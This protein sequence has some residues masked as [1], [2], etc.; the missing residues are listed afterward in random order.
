M[1]EIYSLRQGER[2]VG[3]IYRAL[4]AK[5]KDPDYNTDEK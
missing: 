2:T 3:D 5:W 4:K 1:N